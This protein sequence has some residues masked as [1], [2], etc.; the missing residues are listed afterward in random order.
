[1]T[2]AIARAPTIPE[3][4]RYFKGYGDGL[5]EEH[6]SDHYAVAVTFRYE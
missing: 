6:L 5:M 1:M 2:Q 4:A 3:H